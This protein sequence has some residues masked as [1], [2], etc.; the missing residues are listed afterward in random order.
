MIILVTL[1][2]LASYFILMCVE[3]VIHLYNNYTYNQLLTRELKTNIDNR[4]YC[5]FPKKGIYSFFVFPAYIT[6]LGCIFHCN[7]YM[8]PLS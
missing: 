5:Y 8:F 6:L 4:S 2:L 1:L 3:S 7:S